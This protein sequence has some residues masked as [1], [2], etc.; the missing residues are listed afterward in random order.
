MLTYERTPSVKPTTSRSTQAAPT[1]QDFGWK[2]PS[3]KGKR[4]QAAPATP[5]EEA[6]KR[7][8]ER[9][10]EREKALVKQA[11]VCPPRHLSWTLHSL[12]S[13]CTANAS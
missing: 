10:A 5:S 3:K 4:A 6:I 11:K 7:F 13:S 2:D 8:E 12:N 9:Q 1:P